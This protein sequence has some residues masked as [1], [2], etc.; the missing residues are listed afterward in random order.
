MSKRV[1]SGSLLRSAIETLAPS[2]IARN[3]HRA[4]FA[5]VV[6]MAN[7][8]RKLHPEP[9]DGLSA[10]S[11]NGLWRLA[12]RIELGAVDFRFS[13]TGDVSSTTMRLR[14]QTIS[15][16]SSMKPCLY[17][18]PLRNPLSSHPRGGGPKK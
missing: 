7:F 6:G 16:S 8:H 5:Y 15:T 2:K 14:R 12:E 4:R 3:S 9:I 17:G 11:P 10:R 18:N 13:V 1:A